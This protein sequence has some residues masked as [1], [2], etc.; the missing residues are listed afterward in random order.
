MARARPP[1]TLRFRVVASAVA[2]LLVLGALEVAARVAAPVLPAFAVTPGKEASVLLNP[3]PTRLWYTAPGLK[4]S[5]G[6]KASI[7]T[8]GL[9]GALPADPKPEGRPRVLLLGDSSIY[10]H[11]VAD[12]ETLAV[13]LERALY[14]QGVAAEVINGGTPGYSTEQTIRFLDEVGWGL[15]P[16]L[17]IVGNLWSDNNYD[18][19]QDADLLRTVDAFAG[20]LAGSA[21]YRL[22]AAWGDR[23]RGGRGARVVTWTEG[24]QRPAEGGRRVPLPAYAANLA[25]IADGARARG[26]GVV[27][28]ALTNQ[29]R[30]VDDRPTHSWGPYFAAQRAVANWYGLP[31]LDAQFVFLASGKS[32]DALFVDAMH[33]SA[34]GFRLLAENAARRLTA[35]GWPAAARYAPRDA[36]FPGLDF[37][38]SQV[39]ASPD[40]ASLQGQL[41][42]PAGG[43]PAR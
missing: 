22:S 43:A 21:L 34:E 7:N 9:R 24:D 1:R 19:F 28:L 31:V 5:A 6:F 13:Q 27:Y 4:E 30:Q 16:D 11:G 40:G 42:E 37:A 15:E 12:D 26:V 18:L 3:H 35:E 20:P 36:P 41:F 14:A 38:D 10:G 29:L 23:L 39:V 32:G 8:L 17:L 33:P 25:A 2:A